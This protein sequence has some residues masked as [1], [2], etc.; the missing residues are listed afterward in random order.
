MRITNV[1]ER[2][3]AVPADRIGEL[4]NTLAS[5]NDMFWPHEN[6]PAVKFD[7]PL[8]VGATGGHGTGPY[9]ITS[10]S[11]GR[12]IR[13]DFVGGGRHGF[14]EFEIR[15]LAGGGSLLRHFLD[16]QPPLLGLYVWH[17]RIRPLHDAVLEDLFDK[18]E[19]QVS[20]VARPQIWSARV[21]RLR[22]QRGLP[23][24]KREI[25][26]EFDVKAAAN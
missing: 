21:I 7:R 13:F 17:A 25:A 4:L 18:V 8:Q 23:A 15:P 19:A 26:C 14:H 2:R 9:T 1:H 22:A 5:D 24:E 16:A 10:Y 3:I 12:H 6:W 20:R 11:P